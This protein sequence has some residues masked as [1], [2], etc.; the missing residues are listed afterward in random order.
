MFPDVKF[1]RNSI[2]KKVDAFGI[3]PGHRKQKKRDI[4]TEKGYF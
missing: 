1:S 4:E 2:K 3:F